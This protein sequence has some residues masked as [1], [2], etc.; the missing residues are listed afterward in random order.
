MTVSEMS[1][2]ELRQRLDAEM[3]APVLLDVREPWELERAQLPNSVC[4][5]MRELSFRLE[6]LEPQQD[7]VVLCHH[8]IRSRI[9]CMLLQRAGFERIFNLTGGIDAWARQVEPTMPLY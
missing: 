9:A 7:T 4:I 6:E 1:P 2:A 5:P 8:G 3:S